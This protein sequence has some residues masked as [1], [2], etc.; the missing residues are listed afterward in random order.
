MLLNNKKCR[1]KGKKLN[2]SN[3]AND[4]KK[5]MHSPYDTNGSYTGTSA[6]FEKPVQD[7]DDL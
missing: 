7:A 6:K 5:Q 4:I 2:E 3:R 1:Q